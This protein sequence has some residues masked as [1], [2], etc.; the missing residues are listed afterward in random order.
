MTICGSCGSREPEGARF[1]GSCGA[2][3]A[4]AEPPETETVTCAS[5]GNEEPAGTRFCGVCGS[6]L[7][8]AAEPEAVTKE[9]AA[10][11]PTAEQHAAVEAPTEAV[12]PAELPQAAPS[13]PVRRIPTGVLVGGVVLV[14]A[15]AAVGALFGTGVIGGSSGTS[16]SAFVSGVNVNVLQP[17]GQADQAAAGDRIVRA[18]DDGFTYL[19][20]MSSLSTDQKGQVELLVAVL[21]ANRAYGQALAAFSPDDTA[22]QAAVAAAAATTRAALSTAASHLDPGLAVPSQAVIVTPT[23]TTTTTETTSS[24]DLDA[25]YVQEVDALLRRSHGVVLGLRSF[26][27][28]ASSG[29]ISRG[30]AVVLARSFANSRRVEL[31]RARALVVPAE[32]AQAHQLLVD[33][34]QTSL[35]DDEALVAW[36]EARRDGTGGA[37]AAF[38]RANR[39]GTQATT[40]KRLFLRVYGPAR[41]SATGLSPASLPTDY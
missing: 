6:S 38:A 12:P 35:D 2:P 37:R 22:G 25:A 41:R 31:E 16:R 39:I 14:V 30:A 15:G 23:V 4:A 21:A 18:V 5:C 32:F 10:G 8:P 28:R 24:A 9:P 26:I 33:S 3:I 40:Q 1:C 11:E 13:E 7:A 17:L 34:L 27:R 36:T 29:A 19:R 20:R